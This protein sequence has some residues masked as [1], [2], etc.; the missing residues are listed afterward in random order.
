MRL[1]SPLL[2]RVVY[3]GL[4]QNSPEFGDFSRDLPP[5]AN[6]KSGGRHGELGSRFR[7]LDSKFSRASIRKF[8]KDLSVVRHLGIH[9]DLACD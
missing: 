8:D 9:R 2:K 4:A 1:V 5:G 3:P 7:E 6:A